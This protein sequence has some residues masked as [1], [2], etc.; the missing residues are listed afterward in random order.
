[1]QKAANLLES[2]TATQLIDALF[3]AKSP[4]MIKNLPRPLVGILLMNAGCM[5][6]PL[7]DAAIKLA[8]ARYPLAQLL[9]IRFFIPC[10][11]V[12]LLAWRRYGP[13]VIVTGKTL[14]LVGRALFYF[15]ASISFVTAIKHLPLAD[16]AAIASSEPVIL[17]LLSALVLRERITS[18]RWYAVSLGMVATLMIIR[19]GLDDYNPASPFALFAAFSA[20]GY[21]FMNRL[22]AHSVPP[23]VTMS[24]TL[25][26]ILLVLTTAM[27]FVWVKPVPTEFILITMGSLANICGHLLILRAFVL[28]EASLLAPFIYSSMITNVVAGYFLFRDFP[29][30]WTLLGVIL[31][32]GTGVY[33]SL[34]DKAVAGATTT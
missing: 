26:L 4:Q 24:Y 30:I 23:L 34:K 28:A 17:V 32:V 10:C 11:L 8:G 16:A 3:A 6:L 31:L 25:S 22:L 5:M 15:A 1:M 33:L 7:C 21:M 20:A 27:P 12:L 18:S 9:W 19:P 29:D 2:F 14:L 13:R